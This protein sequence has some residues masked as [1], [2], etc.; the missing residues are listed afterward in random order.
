LK[1]LDNLAKPE[2]MCQP[3]QVCR[4]IARCLAGPPRPVETVILPWGLPLSIRPAEDIGRQIWAMGVF[5]LCVTETLWR[6]VE[7]GELVI[8]VGAN[9]GHMTS[10]MSVRAGQRGRVLSFEPHPDVFRDL[11]EQLAA[12]KQA[13]G[14]TNISARPVALGNQNGQAFLNIPDRFEENRGL[15]QVG[16]T[17]DGLRAVP[18]EIRR[19]A[20]VLDREDGV[21]VMKIDVEGHELQVLE[22]ADSLLRERRLRDVV[23]E[24]R[25]GADSPAARRLRERGYTIYALRARLGGPRLEAPGQNLTPLRIWEVPSC[26]ATLEPDRVR[27]KFAARGWQALRGHPR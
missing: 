23:F 26:L 17:A 15:A 20:D 10:V 6:L 11:S 25:E 8:D 18:I 9:I 27:E 16:E 19:L 14:W 7:P 12:W 3:A 22:G 13:R 5:D 4:R 2:Y 24:T 1:L 21:G